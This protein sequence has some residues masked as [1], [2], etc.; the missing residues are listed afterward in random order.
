VRGYGLVVGLN[1][2]G[3]REGDPRVR[4]FMLEEM[5]RRGV[6]SNRDGWSGMTPEQLLDSS[7]TSIVIVEGVIPP[8][9]VGRLALQREHAPSSG[10]PSERL[11]LRGTQ[12]DV[13]VYADPRSGTTSIE[14]GRLYTSELRPGQLS[15]S[16]RQSFPLAEAYGQVYVNPF[17]EPGG[18]TRDTINRT[19]GRI[20]NGGEVLEDMPLKL[21]L[22]RP[23]HTRAA[24][25]VTA[26]N[27]RFVQ[28]PGQRDPTARGESDETIEVAVPP[29]Y[30]DRTL[31]FVELLRHTSLYSRGQEAL[32][33]SIKRTV[34]ANPAMWESASWRWQAMGKKVLP[35]IR[36]LYDSAD[37][38]PRRAALRAGARLND[39]LVVPHVISMAEASSRTARLEAIEL[40]GD[41]GI[42]PRV[43]RALRGLLNDPDVEVRLAAYEASV[44]RR[45]PFL[46]RIP[47]A[48]KFV[49][50]LIE[51]DYPMIYIT[52]RSQPRIAVFS[53]SM[54]IV[55]PL[56]ANAWSN[57]LIIKEY[58][59]SELEIYYRR[60]DSNNGYVEHINA[61]VPELIQF[62]GHE[63][64]PDSPR[65][66]LGL[67]YGEVVGALHAIWKQKYLTADFKTERDRILRA[68]MDRETNTEIRQR[69]LFESNPD[70]DPMLDD[71]RFIAP[72]LLDGMQGSVPTDVDP[73]GD[74][75]PRQ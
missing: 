7:D 21:R 52:Q 20:L 9:S 70:G 42:F 18:G 58:G 59:T 40:L 60:Q 39:A 61:N 57:R 6:G 19:T 8:A 44:D 56:T 4:N 32:A 75:E 15:A 16:S 64:S 14:G 51:S 45:D 65:S 48:D 63:P 55:R 1:G 68:I 53:P 47:V 35:A 50:D 17:A 3:S 23:S 71:E 31:E 12:F 33:I 11:G 27:A 28:E 5:R 37:E 25:V 73:R 26:V 13:R 67:T 72:P 22:A 38:R 69:P 46:N 49:L 41:M 62:F 36:D 29:S 74:L 66:G 30:R 10:R 54:E 2:T 43:D 24:A 34:E